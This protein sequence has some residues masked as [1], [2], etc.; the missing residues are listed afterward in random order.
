MKKSLEVTQNISR[1]YKNLVETGKRLIKKEERERKWKEKERKKG[2]KERRRDGGEN[3]RLK[4]KQVMRK[5]MECNTLFSPGTVVLQPYGIH[6]LV[7][8]LF[9]QSIFWGSGLLFHFS[10]VF[11]CAAFPQPLSGRWA[12]CELVICVTFDPWSLSVLLQRVRAKVTMT[13]SP[14]QS[15]KIAVSPFQ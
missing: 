3:F 11:V 6:R 4:G 1:Q 13:A 5:H 14:S 2:R 9:F 8:H 10:G 7:I 15:C 12:Q